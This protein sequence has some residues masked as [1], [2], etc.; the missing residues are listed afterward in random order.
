MKVLVALGLSLVASAARANPLDTF[1]FGSRGAAMGDAQAADASDFSAN[2]YN[3]AGLALAHKFEI[4]IGYFRATQDLYTNGQNNNVDPVAGLVGGIVLPGRI[5]GLPVAFGLGLHL[6]DD[7][8]SRVRSLP[9]D[10]PVWE[11]YD[12]RNQRVYLAANLAISP[13]PWLQIGGGLSFMASTTGTLSISGE[14]NVFQVGESQVRHEVDASLGAIRYPQAGAR[15]ELGKRAALAVVYRGQFS[16]SLELAAS[17]YGEIATGTMPGEGLTTA[18]YTLTTSSV[19]AFLPQQVVVGGS[20]LPLDRLKVDVDFT[21]VNWSAYVSPVANLDVT[22]N[23]PP[24]AGGWPAGIMPPTVPQKTPIL[25]LVMSDRIVPHLGLELRALERGKWRGFLRAGYSYQ[26]SPIAAQT[27]QTNYIDR[28]RHE[29]TAGVGFQVDK[30]FTILPGDVR[31]DL[32]AQLHVLPF[33]VT[34]KTNPADFVGDF[35][36]GGYLW[37]LG[38]TMT[39]GF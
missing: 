2:Y 23:I 34:E 5:L 11:L 28:D 17:L 36:A 21:W 20:F 8:L 15:I 26:K 38:A 39:V 13:W 12:N 22:L 25:P 19:D 35:S 14:A 3:P 10:Q 33:G 7:R 6:P 27:G 37:N 9:Q 1:G 16:L 30:P 31:F 32:H 4:S 29:I 18:V 24:P